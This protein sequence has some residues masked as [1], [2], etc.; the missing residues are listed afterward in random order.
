MAVSQTLSVTKLPGSVDNVA[1]TSKVQILWQSTQTGDS[2]NGYTRT[3][4]FYVSIN[5]GAEKEYS[6]TYTLPKATTKTIVDTIITVNHKSDG[7]GTV[8]VRTWMD[9]GIS[10]G[11]VEK[12]ATLTLPTIPRAST[13]SYLSDVTLGNICTLK[14]TPCS[15]DFHFKIKFTIGSWALTT[16]A[17]HPKV[18]TLY[19]NASY[20]I[21]LDAAHQFPNS[22]NADMTVTLYTY[23]DEAC[24]KQ[25]GTAS[26]K[27]CKVYIPEN[28]NTLPKVAMS[29]SPIS[30]LPDAFNGLYIQNKTRVKADF[31][32]SEA[33]Y[34]ANIAS[35]SMTVNGK[36]YSDPYRSD[37]LSKYGT[38]SVV[39][40]VTDTRGCS[41]SAPQDITVIPY[42]PP[43][44]I[45][46]SGESSIV[47]KRCTADG[48]ISPS[49]THL[50][51]KAG[52]QY[53]KV[54]SDGEQ[55][56]FCLM[57]LNYKTEE[58]S[59]W[60]AWVNLLDKDDE[61]DS[62]DVA[63]TNISLAISRTYL[64][65]I[66]V[67]D[68]VGETYTMI[69][70]V[71]TADCTYHL[72]KGGKAIGI[73]KYAEEDYIVDIDDEW[74]VN[75]RGDVRIGGKLFLQDKELNVVIEEGVI[76]KNTA[77][78]TTVDWH[79]RKWL[80]GYAEC[81]CRRNIDVD[82][83]TAWGSGLYYGMATTINYP[84]VF[85][86]RPM[87]QVTCEYGEDNVSLFVA[88]SGKGTE[89]YATPV[90]LCRSDSK[91]D[92]NCNILYNV[93]GKWK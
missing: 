9:T 10:A 71:P 56:N 61:I 87:C 92:V 16:A 18:T 64:V 29:L 22:K 3:A 88:S 35:C 6:I 81:W 5:G 12:S 46:Y 26:T 63:L 15:K 67:V 89:I 55:K 2:W 66:E 65:K 69:I 21:S 40:K 85:A 4:K 53:N 48:T 54:I 76:S 93:H 83:T 13:I 41:A 20:G 49:G 80:N 58:S 24:T 45:P 60:I 31:T 17:I 50:R 79:Y 70:T 19:T 36:A 38:I 86:E 37:L 90:M 1:N 47:C 33:K 42:S 14:W 44:I 82:I 72:R 11:V 73:G 30:S 57:R 7:T 68:D 59:S 78:G 23:S 28:E 52:R 34:S 74:K 43:S 51:I 77:E 75:A 32:G 27:T 25:I 91:T 8:K 39:G 84:F 62:V